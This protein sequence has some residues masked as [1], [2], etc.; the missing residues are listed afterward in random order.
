M[1]RKYIGETDINK[2]NGVPILHW[3]EWVRICQDIVAGRRSYIL[4]DNT[5]GLAGEDLKETLVSLAEWDN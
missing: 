2:I 3:K 1:Y 5:W 4:N